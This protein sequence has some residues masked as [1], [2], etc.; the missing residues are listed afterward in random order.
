MVC[1]YGLFLCIYW[2][3]IC[4]ISSFQEFPSTFGCS[5]LKLWLS[6]CLRLKNFYHVFWLLFGVHGVYGWYASLLYIVVGTV[7]TLCI[8]DDSLFSPWFTY[9]VLEG[10]HLKSVWLLN[11]KH[12][13]SIPELPHDWKN[14][15]ECDNENWM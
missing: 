13:D 7:L 1:K 11:L 6:L 14:E 4:L 3:L 2:W 15:K 10:F 8:V 12:R 5:Q 9:D